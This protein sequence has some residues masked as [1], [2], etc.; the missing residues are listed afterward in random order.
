VSER[1]RA[2][3]YKSP[4][5]KLLKPSKQVLRTLKMAGSDMYLKIYPK[6]ETTLASF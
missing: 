6:P 1:L 5:L 4:H 3:T 2:G